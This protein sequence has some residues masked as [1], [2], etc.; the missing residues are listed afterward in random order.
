MDRTLMYETTVTDE[1]VAAS[2]RIITI[3]S[4]FLPPNLTPESFVESLS[5][6]GETIAVNHSGIGQV[7][8]VILAHA[9]SPV[10]SDKLL[11][12]LRLAAAEGQYA[13]NIDIDPYMVQFGQYLATDRIAPFEQSALS[14]GAI[15][16]I[17]GSGISVG[18]L[19]AANPFI[20][21]YA[22]GGIVVV[23]ATA[24][25]GAGLFELL[26]KKIAGEQ[27]RAD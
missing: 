21:I 23:F 4:R 22:A 18:I 13:F 16:T 6:L 10:E 27:N 24:A 3:P 2:A 15:A 12:E 5:E 1:R 20:Y 9:V 25:L 17:A 19:A 7:L 8:S 26:R 11:S 14:A